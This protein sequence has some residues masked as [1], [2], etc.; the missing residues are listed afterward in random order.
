MSNPNIDKAREYAKKNN[1]KLTHHR[2]DN[3]TVK[4]TKTNRGGDYTRFWDNILRLLRG[5]DRRLGDSYEYVPSPYNYKGKYPEKRI[6]V[7]FKKV[8]KK[9]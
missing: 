9:E 4:F 6:E 1:I 5:I 2:N 7:T 3:V 8:D